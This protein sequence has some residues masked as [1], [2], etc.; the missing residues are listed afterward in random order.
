MNRITSPMIANAT[1]TAVLS[2]NC[3]ASA[4]ACAAAAQFIQGQMNVVSPLSQRFATGL[5]KIDYRRSD[6]NTFGVEANAMN[7]RFPQG[8]QT[9][10]V[11]P[12]GG[13]LGIG[14]SRDDTRYGKASWIR[15]LSPTWINEARFGMFE[16]RFSDPASQSNLSTGNAGIDVAGV[17]LGATH[18]YAAAMTERR[19]QL[20]DN[21]SMTALGHSL[22]LGS[23]RRRRATRSMSL[24]TPTA[25]TS[26]RR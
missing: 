24:P 10:N 3:K 16:D 23:T 22:K 21:F 7:S 25:P 1:G 18:P 2:T 6:R 4:T 12:D 5:A 15:T 26:I 20:V 14:N 17:T 8:A 19:Y 11:A 13:L 9:G